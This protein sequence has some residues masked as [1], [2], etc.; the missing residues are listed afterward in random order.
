MAWLKGQAKCVDKME[1][2]IGAFGETIFARVKGDGGAGKGLFVES[3][4]ENAIYLARLPRP[5][6]R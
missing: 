4:G 6:F 1:K 5:P 2:P 3:P